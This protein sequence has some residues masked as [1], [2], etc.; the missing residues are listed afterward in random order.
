M[1]SIVKSLRRHC[2]RIAYSGRGM[3]CVFCGQRHQRFLPA[4]SR[5]RRLARLGAIGIGRRPDACCPA[6]GASDRARL[7]LLYLRDA[8]GLFRDPHDKKLLHIAPN[9][10]LARALREAPSLGITW[11]SI[12]PEDFSEFNAV[13]ADIM[14]LPFGDNAFDWVLCNHVLQQVPDDRQAL[15]EIR[16]V[17]NP[18]GRAILQVPWAPALAVTDESLDELDRRERRRRFGSTQ[19]FRLYGTDITERFANEGLTL[20]FHTPSD[21][22]WSEDYA[23]HALNLPEVVML[24]EPLT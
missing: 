17:L 16:R 14:H 22:D 11:G 13:R 19:H 20:S 4:G 15:R 24:A 5:S 3:E 7:L 12:D 9:P 8:A 6:C 2:Y 1:S 10:A 23:R 18:G 21:P